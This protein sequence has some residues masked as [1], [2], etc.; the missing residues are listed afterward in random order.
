MISRIKSIILNL[1]AIVNITVIAL[2]LISGYSDHLNPGHSD[3]LAC[4]GMAFPIFMLANL[5]FVP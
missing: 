1:I 5:L 2:M 3:I 4:A